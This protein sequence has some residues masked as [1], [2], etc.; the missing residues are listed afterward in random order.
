MC[1][2]EGAEVCAPTP[3]SGSKETYGP[4]PHGYKHT[5]PRSKSLRPGPA[6]AA[7]VGVGGCEAGVPFHILEVIYDVWG[8]G[9]RPSSLLEP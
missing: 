9:R 1:V 3:P 6:A 2:G 7:R 4:L 5:P 8:L